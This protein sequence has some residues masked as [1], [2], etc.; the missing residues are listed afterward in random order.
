MLFKEMTDNQR[1]IFIDTIQLYE[2]FMDTF[3]KSRSYAGGM[4]WKKSK[5]REYLFRTKDRY[6]Y[7]K[8][9]GVRSSETEKILKEFRQT[10]KEL[11]QRM[12]LFKARLKE[13]ARFCKAA[14][15]QRVP[16]IVTNILRLLDQ[17]KL[18]GKNIMVIGTDALYAYEASAAVFFDSPMMATRDMDILWDIRPKL[19]L[20]ADDK[21]EPEGLMGIIRK[22]DRSFELSGSRSFQAVN[23]DG[24]MI[25]LI[26][27]A[28]K[29]IM[30][31]ERLRMGGPGDLEAVEIKNLQWLL[32]SP[33][34]S[35]IVIGDD[36][37]PSAMV[38]PD[39][40]AFSLHKIWLSGQLDR[41]P[42][43]KQRDR[44]QALAVAQ[45]VIKY[46][47]QY[48]FRKPE[49][50]MFPKELLVEAQAQISQIEGVPGFEF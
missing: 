26:K 39:P 40:R 44:N 2:A 10:K 37:Y 22:S 30:P 11:N 49:L 1:R 6:G 5:G 45:L 23:R 34:F 7:G 29:K 21:I 20:V 13:Q 18:L 16:R 36:G 14:M 50:K 48:A 46:L 31:E 41:E 32:S 17:Q 24:Y 3:P 15:I 35:Q 27:A 4:H 9:L 38:V 43:K 42:T 19:T 25:D 8:S 28:P 33:K 47:P 12:A